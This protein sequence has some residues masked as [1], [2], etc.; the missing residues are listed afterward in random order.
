M[1]LWLCRQENVKNPFYMEPMG[2]YLYSSQELSYVIFNHPLLVLDD[3]V[4]EELLAFLRDELNQ[5]FLALKLERW[6]KSG[7][8]PDEMLTLILQECDYYSAADITHFR[9]QV[10]ALRKKHPAEYRKLKADELFSMR[11]YGRAA[12]LYRGL[13]DYPADNYV[14]EMFVGRIWNNLGSCYARMCQ[15]EPALEAYEKAYLYTKQQQVLEQ[16][17]ELVCLDGRLTPSD[18]ISTLITDELRTQSAERVAQA[19]E[20]AA[21]AEAVRGIDELFARDP[22]KR[23]AG[24]AALLGRWKQEYRSMV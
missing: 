6:Q 20:H 22:I 3:F 11:Q 4:S 9:Q 14:D 23:Q 18:R 13:L 10:Q 1:S 2:I 12:K 15:P 19:Q 7:E 17:C 5:G 21:D 16:I 24:A 8:S